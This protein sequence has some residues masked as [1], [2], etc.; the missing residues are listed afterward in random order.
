M[1]ES[2]LFNV[3]GRTGIPGRDE[4]T[5]WHILEK[6][7]TRDAALEKA[8]VGNVMARKHEVD[9]EYMA[10]PLKRRPEDFQA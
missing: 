10:L 2:M 4:K 8:N 5:A 3:W 7:M 1:A 6:E 9:M